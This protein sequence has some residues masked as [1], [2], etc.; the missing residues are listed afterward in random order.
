MNRVLQW[1]FFCGTPTLTLVTGTTY[2]LLYFVQKAH[3]W[4]F[5]ELDRDIYYVCVI[6]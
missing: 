4:L 5:V 1:H 3:P 2:L 6:D